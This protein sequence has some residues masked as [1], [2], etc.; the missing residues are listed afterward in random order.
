MKYFMIDEDQLNRLEAV[1]ARLYSERRRDGGEMRNAAQRIHSVIDVC[2]KIEV[3]DA[4][5]D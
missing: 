3:H 5:T 2:R 4:T 1:A